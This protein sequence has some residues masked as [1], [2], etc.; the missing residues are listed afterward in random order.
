[1]CRAYPT[2]KLSIAT[3][4][5]VRLIHIVVVF[6]YFLMRATVVWS[7]HLHG[8][9]RV[10]SYQKPG[11]GHKKPSVFVFRSFICQYLSQKLKYDTCCRLP[12]LETAKCMTHNQKGKA[13]EVN[14]LTISALRWPFVESF[15]LPPFLLSIYWPPRE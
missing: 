4:I 13:K 3:Y 14:T 6:F 11:P 5:S 15:S 12:P 1:M 10:T 2:N 8:I 9:I 7:E